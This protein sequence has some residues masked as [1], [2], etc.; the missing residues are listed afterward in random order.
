ML[1]KITKLR[2]ELHQNPELSGFEVQTAERLINFITSNCN[3]QI[4][5]SI[6]GNGFVAVFDFHE[7]GPTIGF[8]C[9]LDALP[10]HE[11]NTISY[12]SKVDGVSHKCGHDGHMAIV[13]GLLFWI[14]ERAFKSGKIVLI[15]QPAEETGK[16]AFKMINDRR[17]KQL[18]LDYIFAL[19]NIPG[20]PL[21][22]ILITEPSFSA[23]VQSLAITIKG[24]KSHAAE[25]ENGINPA[26]GIS[27]I[28]QELAKLNHTNSESKNFAIVT[29]IHIVMGEKAYGISPEHAELHY[30]IRTWDEHM[31]T[32]I[33]ETIIAIIK[34][35]C[36]NLKVNHKP[37]PF[38]FGEDFGWFSRTYKT[39]M[40]GIGSGNNSPAL[41]H[42]NYDFPDAIIKTGI[43]MYTSLIEN[44]LSTKSE[45]V[46]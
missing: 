25:P 4:I 42:A 22:S 6:G 40:F 14:K 31:M 1:T 45:N 46:L 5:S 27:Y 30:T 8:R 24:K 16:G 33:K 38:R 32:H 20:E 11:E 37:Q 28:I 34:T 17:F 29:P 19:H 41:H 10:I 3:A 2:K 43:A 44:L 35:L 12:R 9:E 21:H 13:S 23:E 26:V 15:F 39:A 7:K 36:L 18:K